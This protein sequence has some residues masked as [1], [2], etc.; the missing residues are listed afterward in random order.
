[1]T[2]GD[3]VSHLEEDV[4]DVV[5]DQNERAHPRE[6]AGP[7]ECQQGDSGHVM[8]EHLPKVLPLG[9][10]KLR[11]DQRPVEGQLDHVVPPHA[12]VQRVSRNEA[13]L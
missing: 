9:V 13:Y 4:C 12:G 11:D 2:S 8:H 1:V 6:V 3:Q 5:R 10:E 7:A